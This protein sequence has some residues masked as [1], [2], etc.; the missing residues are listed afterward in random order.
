MGSRGEPVG[1]A[2]QLGVV[3]PPG[4]SEKTLPAF[5][6]PERPDEEV[7]QFVTD[8]LFVVERARHEHA[9]DTMVEGSHGEVPQEGDPHGDDR[10]DRPVVV[11]HGVDEAQ[12]PKAPRFPDGE[13]LGDAAADVMSHQVRFPDTR[14]VH[15]AQDHIGL[16]GEGVVRPGR[17]GR[18]SAPHQVG[19]EE[20]EVVLQERYNVLPEKGVGGDAV[21]KK[22][23]IPPPPRAVGY[24]Q[25]SHIGKPHPA[26]P[27]KTEKP[28]F[29]CRYR[30][31]LL[32]LGA[33]RV[34]VK[35]EWPGLPPRRARDD[36]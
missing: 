16:G 24:S 36:T 28:L 31:P 33:P 22:G 14:L 34:A 10:L 23:R 19:G 8:L 18:I 5:R 9:Q 2:Q 30:H 4:E 7:H 13:D 26:L 32:N 6:C 21:K 1:D 35:S 25:V 20:G 11:S 15:E 3:Q 29:P 12:G 27:G 17:L